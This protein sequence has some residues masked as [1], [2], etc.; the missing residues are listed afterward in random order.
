MNDVVYRVEKDIDFRRVIESAEIVGSRKVLFTGDIN[1]KI[2]ALLKNMN[3]LLMQV[4]C[5][6]E[7]S[8]VLL[9]RRKNGK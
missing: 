9:I 1:V 2:N 8:A 4:I 5:F 7:S 6:C 3:H